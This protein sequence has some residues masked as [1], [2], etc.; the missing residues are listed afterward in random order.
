[1]A[2]VRKTSPCAINIHDGSLQFSS[3][4][5][6]YDD[7][8]NAIENCNENLIISGDLDDLILDGMKN[9][10]DQIIIG[11]PNTR[12]AELADLTAAM[13]VLPLDIK[14]CPET[15]PMAALEPR[16]LLFC[17]PDPV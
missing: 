5:G 3:L 11:L 17:R 7:D 1:M 12:T 16:R 4:A 2:S 8:Q 13:S 15:M 10:F 14:I 9:K 6:V